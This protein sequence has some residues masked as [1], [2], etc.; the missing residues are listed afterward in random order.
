MN[1]NRSEATPNTARSRCRGSFIAKR[2]PPP[3]NSFHEPICVLQTDSLTSEISEIKALKHYPPHQTQPP[4]TTAKESCREHPEKTRR[5]AKPR[6][7]GADPEKA[8][9]DLVL[10]RSGICT[11]TTAADPQQ[12]Y[13]CISQKTQIRHQLG[14]KSTKPPLKHKPEKK[15]R[16][17][18]K[19]GAFYGEKQV[20]RRGKDIA[21]EENSREK[22]RVKRRRS[23]AV[24][25]YQLLVL[26]I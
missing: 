25:I 20:T 24:A 7:D 23:K 4:A 18:R 9:P 22:G 6:E 2:Q 8:S 15:N 16:K 21:G 13:H 3:E 1:K 14:R 17:T 12:S 5:R 26:T 10:I 11:G 19:D